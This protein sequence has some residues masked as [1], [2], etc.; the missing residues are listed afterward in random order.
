MSKINGFNESEDAIY[1]IGYEQGRTDGIEKFKNDL[2]EDLIKL[3]DKYF[4]LATRTTMPERYMH[5]KRMDT[6]DMITEMVKIKAE[7]LKGGRE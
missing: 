2:I 6:V 3:E 5:L 1:Q 7:S 4:D